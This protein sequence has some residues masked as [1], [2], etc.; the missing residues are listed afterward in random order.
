M[1]CC[2]ALLLIRILIGQFF[3]IPREKWYKL[4]IPHLMK[5]EFIVFKKKL[6]PNIERYKLHKILSNLI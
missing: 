2:Q 6:Y 5:L 3:N 1:N 4:N